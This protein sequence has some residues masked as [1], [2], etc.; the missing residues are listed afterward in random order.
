MVAVGL[1]PS[2]SS[3]WLPSSSWPSSVAPQYSGCAPCSP[4]KTITTRVVS[5]VVW[6]HK[7]GFEA[8]VSIHVLYVWCISHSHQQ[9]QP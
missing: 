6:L 7:H 5:W 4:N 3:K 9:S 2:S 8:T 1:Q